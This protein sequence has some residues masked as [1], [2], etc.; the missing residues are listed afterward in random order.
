MP[1]IVF[2]DRWVSD[3]PYLFRVFKK[4]DAQHMLEKAMGKH[5]IKDIRDPKVI[6]L[7]L[8]LGDTAVTLGQ[9][10]G[11]VPSA[12]LFALSTQATLDGNSSNLPIWLRSG[13]LFFMLVQL[14]LLAN[15]CVARRYLGARSRVQHGHQDSQKALLSSDA[16]H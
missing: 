1:S 16:S 5:A 10:V 6:G 12:S 9:G 15:L 11:P 4:G 14:L 3:T 13:R 8:A 2:W 7:A